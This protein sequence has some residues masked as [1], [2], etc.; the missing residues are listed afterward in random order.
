[1]TLTVAGQASA[2]RGRAG[3][4]KGG[5][6]AKQVAREPV[7]PTSDQIVSAMEDIDWGWSHQKLISHFTSALQKMYRPLLGKATDA[8]REDQLRSE[9]NARI[10]RIKGSYV[11]FSGQHTGWDTSMLRDQ[12]THNNNE[13]L[14]EVR[15]IRTGTEDPRYTDY[16]FF[17]NDKLWRRYR[18]F[19]QDQFEGIPFEGAAAS[20]EKRF[21][22]SRHVEK[23]GRLIGLEWQD[24]KTRLEAQDQTAF[25]GIFCLI[26]SEK[27]TERQLDKLRVNTKSTKG[28]LNPLV[29]ALDDTSEHDVHSDVVEHITGKRYNTAKQQPEVNEQPGKSTSKTSPSKSPD[30]PA[31]RKRS[32]TGDPLDDL[33][34]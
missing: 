24:S 30:A 12:Y 17:I 5:G 26:F 15:E 7:T 31:P 19:S 9:M 21:G 25:Y 29:E 28:G 16:F 22:P 18:A 3:G 32:S 20:F 23:S 34:I 14:V 4:R 33:E 11:E 1:V 27:D 2:E 10:A 6:G 8:I 13:A